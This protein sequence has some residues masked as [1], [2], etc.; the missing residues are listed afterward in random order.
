MG[1]VIDL[2]GG[3]E[4]NY[5]ALLEDFLE[6]F[7]KD[8]M[9]VTDS[10][11]DMAFDISIRAWNIANSGVN[12]PDDKFKEFLSLLPQETIMDELLLKMVNYKRTN[13]GEYNE[14]FVSYDLDDEE[15]EGKVTLSV[16]T[17][18][19]ASYVERMNE[20]AF[21]LD[22]LEEGFINRYAVILKPKK[23]FLDWVSSLDP[24]GDNEGCNETNIYLVDD[25]IDDFEVW[26]RKKFDKFFSEILFGW[27]M[28]KKDWPQRR[29]YKMFKEWFDIDVSTAIYDLEQ[30]PIQKG[31]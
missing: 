8:L 2:F 15:G 27:S 25:M 24:D 17:E 14:Y 3:K 12:I 21:D 13:F 31:L 30:S 22:E 26:Q 23:P 11:L 4:A 5:S 29:S 20:E 18:D 9:K 1:K 28:N 6:F 7:D 19:E 10:D 16:E